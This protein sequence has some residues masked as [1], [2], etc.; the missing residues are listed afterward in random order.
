MTVTS[1]GGDF[2]VVVTAVMTDGG[3]LIMVTYC[4]GNWC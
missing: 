1:I 3:D 4:G 2:V